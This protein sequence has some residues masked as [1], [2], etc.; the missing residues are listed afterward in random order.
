[1]APSVLVLGGTL[2]SVALDTGGAQSASPQKIQ[3]THW[4]PSPGTLACHWMPLRT[5]TV[6][7]LLS[8]FTT[9]FKLELHAGIRAFRCALYELKR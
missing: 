8:F 2:L 3:E 5:R 4:Q 9:L 1:M 7:Y 6:D